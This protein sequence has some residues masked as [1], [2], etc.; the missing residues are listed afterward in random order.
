[1]QPLAAIGLLNTP[2]FSAGRIVPMRENGSP[3]PP[4]TNLL[5]LHMDEGSGTSLADSSGLSQ[6]GEVVGGLAWDSG[7]L[8]FEGDITKYAR[9]VQGNKS[10]LG[11]ASDWQQSQNVDIEVHINGGGSGGGSIFSTSPGDN[12][13][14]GGS[15][16]IAPAAST[17]SVT[18]ESPY[19]A[20]YSFACALD[21]SI[22]QKL[23]FKWIG[24]SM[25]LYI[26]DVLQDTQTVPRP[27]MPS[28]G[29]FLIGNYWN[30]GYAPPF[31]GKIWG[32]KISTI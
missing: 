22:D 4:V 23:N 10:I 2:R 29:E 15:N 31:T 9:I 14:A 6:T 24:D 5:E 28:V 30:T 17:N 26:N 18:I 32:L 16:G 21:M 19:V 1:M 13:G 12:F 7:A 20:D 3:S 8:V 11:L 25:A 27:A